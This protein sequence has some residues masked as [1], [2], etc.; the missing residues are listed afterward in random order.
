MTSK[1][2]G[3]PVALEKN[4]RKTF[5]AL[6][7]TS[8]RDLSRAGVPDKI[9]MQLMGHKTRSIYDR[10]NMVNEE[11]ISTALTRAE[12]YRARRSHNLATSDDVATSQDHSS[13]K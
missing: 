13:K 4:K 5:H 9:A 7:C 6:R 11:D 12:E 3:L 8:A 10:Y 2:A 1:K